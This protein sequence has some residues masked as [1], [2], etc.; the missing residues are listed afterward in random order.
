MSAWGR[1]LVAAAALSAALSACQ[2][3][4]AAT[5]TRA[6]T[7]A[8][9]DSADQVLFGS[10]SVMTD[11]GVA[12]ALLLSDTAFTYQDATRLELRQVNVTFYTDQ[13]VKDGTMTS[14]EATYDVR[15]SRL[16][17]RG[18]VVLVR[19]DGR[20]LTTE[21]LVYDQARNQVFSDSAFVLSEP[22]KQQLSGIGFETTPQFET[23]RILSNAKGIVP[24]QVPRR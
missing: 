5:P 16:E 12:K 24:V 18:S 13:G 7:T 17:A 1:R 22:G 10:R 20:R 14:R 2:R 19:E 8:L 6:A 21:Q 9:P 15:L 11:R 23:F 3:N 4:T